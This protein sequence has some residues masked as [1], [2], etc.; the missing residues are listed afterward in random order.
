MGVVGPQGLREHIADAGRLHHRADAAA[1]DDPGSRGGRTQQHPARAI[2]PDDLVG[3][4]A[5][6]QGHPHQ[7]LASAIDALADGLGHLAG[8]AEPH[9]D[10][11]V[12]VA[13][14]D[15][16]AEA[17]A[18]AALDDLGHPVD[19]DDAI[20]Q[21]VVVGVQMFPSNSSSH[22]RNVVLLRV[23]PRR[24]PSRGRGRETRCG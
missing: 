7:R 23:R 8:L 5:V 6:H 11:A 21:L 4:R 15:Q 22:V 10:H 13:H 16:R 17:K 24:G 9:A 2:A 1:G 20:G 14:D 12:A 19:V 18:P 3:Q